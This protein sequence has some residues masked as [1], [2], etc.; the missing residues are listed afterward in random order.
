M[1]LEC[2]R[3]GNLL[4]VTPEEYGLLNSAPVALVICVYFLQG[5]SGLHFV[6]LP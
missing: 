5:K 3:R 6:E 4:A 1:L 2:E